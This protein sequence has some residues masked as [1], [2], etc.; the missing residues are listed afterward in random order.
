MRIKVSDQRKPQ[1]THSL[2]GKPEANG[3][4]LFRFG[5]KSEETHRPG[6]PA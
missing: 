4:R 1:Q 6:P 3:L 5:F 2:M